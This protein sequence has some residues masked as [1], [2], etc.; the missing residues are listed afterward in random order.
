MAEIDRSPLPRQVKDLRGRRFG[1]L[2]VVSLSHTKKNAWWNCLCECG[3]MHK[4]VASNLHHGTKTCGCEQGG[5]RHG[6]C[7]TRIYAKWKSM[8][9]RCNDPKEPGWKNYGGRGIKVCR[10]WHNAVN[11][12]ADM[13]E[14]PPAMSI[15]RINNDGDYE[16]S[17]CRWATRAQQNRNNR[18]TR[19]ITYNGKTMCVK[20]WAA[21][22]GIS[23]A[24]LRYRLK[25]W[26]LKRA[27]H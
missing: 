18:R 25:K 22:I 9:R 11:F 14:P 4:V 27:L 20:D 1:K 10:R 7:H 21:H 23:E 24:T 16:R 5:F 26:D 17:N 8:H 12:V 13:G 19:I 6:L 2:L 3:N 15:D